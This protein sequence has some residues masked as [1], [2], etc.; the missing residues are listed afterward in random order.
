MIQYGL[1]DLRRRRRLAQESVDCRLERCNVGHQ[2][3]RGLDI[4]LQ[5]S[6]D[7]I[8]VVGKVQ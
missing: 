5:P 6:F 3:R 7:R 1:T 8:D 4:A 2:T